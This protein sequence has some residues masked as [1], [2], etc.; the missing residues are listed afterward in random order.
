M[1]YEIKVGYIDPELKVKLLDIMDKHKEHL[2]E[3]GKKEE[4]D[5]VDKYMFIVES[6]DK[7]PE[8]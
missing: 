1:V 5:E 2:L 3:Q 7:P 4:A 6:A 8:D